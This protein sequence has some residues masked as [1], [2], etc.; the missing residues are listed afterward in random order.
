MPEMTGPEFVQ[1]WQTPDTRALYM[2]GDI[3]ESLEHDAI[4]GA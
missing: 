2:S 3:D 1:A 4:I